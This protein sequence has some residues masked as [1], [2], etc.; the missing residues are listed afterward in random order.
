MLLV[1]GMLITAFA[2]LP[3]SDIVSMTGVNAHAETNTNE[4]ENLKYTVLDD[5]TVAITGLV[6]RTETVEIPSQIDGKKVTVIKNSAFAALQPN[7]VTT[8]VTLP[9]TLT[10]IEQYA[11]MNM[12]AL[13]SITIPSSVKTIGLGAFYYCKALQTVTFK[14]SIW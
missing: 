11:F 2:F 1:F 4:Y 12:Q 8:K 7:K 13:T 5:G 10:T 3:N 6:S 14:G 9:D